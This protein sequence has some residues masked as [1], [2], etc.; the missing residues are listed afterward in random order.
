VKMKLLSPFRSMVGQNVIRLPT[1][2]STAMLN[3]S[4]EAPPAVDSSMRAD[5][6]AHTR[7]TIPDSIAG[8]TRKV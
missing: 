3:L 6:I 2:P 4:N 7:S 1:M 5:P 8:V